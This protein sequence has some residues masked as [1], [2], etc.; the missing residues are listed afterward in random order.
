[1]AG[2]EIDELVAMLDAD[3]RCT[4]EPG[5]GEQELVAAEQELGHPLPALWRRVLEQVHPFQLPQPPRDADGVL[6]WTRFPDWRLRDVE[7]LRWMLAGPVD[8]VLF[9]VREG[10]WW[11]PWSEPPADVEHR[12]ALAGNLLAQ[13][14]K[15]TPLWA[16]WYLTGGDDPSVLSVASTDLCMPALQLS[17]LPAG[18]R[19]EEDEDVA[20]YPLTDEPFWG[21]LHAWSQV[22]HV[23]TDL[24][25]LGV[26]LD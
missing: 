13:A 1:V 4:L 11:T 7:A 20:A 23:R 22:G 24:G 25:G 2:F 3:E 16:H 17:A 21:L 18:R 5:L 9:H 15:L 26:W 10:F 8:G 19:W 6:R 14:P 12:V